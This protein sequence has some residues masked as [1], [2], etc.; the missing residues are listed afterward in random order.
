VGF[1]YDKKTKAYAAPAGKQKSLVKALEKAG[2]TVSIEVVDEEDEE[3]PESKKG[4]KEPT[5]K[6]GKEPTTKKVGSKKP[7]KKDEDEDAPVKLSNRG[8]FN[9]LAAGLATIAHG[10]AY[11]NEADEDMANALAYA[12]QNPERLLGKILEAFEE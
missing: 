2:Y 9:K 8:I 12:I 10:I 1:T 4:K 11:E 7:A 3:K 6:K 5:A